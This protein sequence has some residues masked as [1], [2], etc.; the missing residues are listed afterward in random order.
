MKN[1][2]KKQRVVKKAKAKKLLPRTMVKKKRLKSGLQRTKFHTFLLK[3][4]S[5]L[6]VREA[7]EITTLRL[8]SVLS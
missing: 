6:E 7:L 3:I 4:D 5:S 1:T 2:E 8:K